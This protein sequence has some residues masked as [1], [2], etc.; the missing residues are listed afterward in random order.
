MPELKLPEVRIPGL[1]DMNTD[2]IRK[3]LS[4]VPRP[5]VKLSDLDPRGIDLSKIEL[6]RVDLAGAANA[7][8]E[9]NPLRQKRRSRAPM[10]LAGLVI[11]GL[12]TLAVMNLGWLRARI[13][14]VADKA[15]ARMDA[16]RVN[17]SLEPI[18]LEAGDYTGTVGIPIQAE[19][20]GDTLPSA[21]PTPVESGFGSTNGTHET[22][23]F[24]AGSTGDTT[25]ETGTTS[26]TGKDA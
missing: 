1:R 13:A 10:V 4:D 3:A 12:G 17:D 15:R 9:R 2:D 19:T 22:S 25:F 20:F 11:A 8:A 18:Q 7:V 21:E 16:S 6:P 23:S 5:D 24:D 26:Q 14:E